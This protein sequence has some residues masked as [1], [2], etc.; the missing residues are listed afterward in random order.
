[1]TCTL[2]D[3]Q[4]RSPAPVSV[5]VQMNTACEYTQEADCRAL[6]IKKRCVAESC[7]HRSRFRTPLAEP[8]A[9]GVVNFAYDLI[10]LGGP[11]AI[12]E[13]VI[14]HLNGSLSQIEVV[15]VDAQ[16]V[17][18]CLVDKSKRMALKN[19]G[20]KSATVRRLVVLQKGWDVE[21]LAIIADSSGYPARNLLEE[22][23]RDCMSAFDFR[24]ILE[25]ETF[26]S[27]TH[28]MQGHDHKE[29]S[30][31]DRSFG[32]VFVVV[33]LL[34]GLWPLTGNWTAFDRIRWW[35]IAISAVILL[36][37]LVYPRLLAP[38]NRLWMKFGLLLH[39]IVSPIMLGGMFFVALTPVAL[40][41]RL[42][43]KD[44]L[45]LEKKPDEKTYWIE[46]ADEIPGSMTN[47]F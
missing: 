45:S 9:V 44:L 11:V 34:I 37:A 2:G 43:G 3:L 7:D 30:S 20:Q 27:S 46:R 38:A 24:I 23:V 47:Q 39:S 22:S 12:I 15:L 35:S 41:M 18:I 16:P 21:H 10:K 33:F 31:S 17:H 28:E 14:Q 29:K 1:M 25:M 5:H 36:V 26:L 6:Q 4:K 42:R 19:K 32:F 13:A 8:G 40:I